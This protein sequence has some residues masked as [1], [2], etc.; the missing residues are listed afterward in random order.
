MF[1]STVIEIIAAIFIVYGIYA[2]FKYLMFL[3]VYESKIRKSISV[4]VRLEQNDSDED[5]KLKIM[6]AK[7]VSRELTPNKDIY[8]IEDKEEQ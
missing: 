5:K 2:S 4:A 7:Q 6:C 8:I 3:A 1:F